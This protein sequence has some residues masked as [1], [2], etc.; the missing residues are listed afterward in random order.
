M[1]CALY[2]VDDE[3]SDSATVIICAVVIPCVIIAVGLAIWAIIFYRKT[4]NLMK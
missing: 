2:D 3:S 1:G 4:R